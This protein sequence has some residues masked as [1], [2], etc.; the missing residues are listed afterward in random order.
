ML[1]GISWTDFLTVLA[2]LLLVYYS[3]LFLAL[4][5]RRL[6]GSTKL[7]HQPNN[8]LL[9]G[10]GLVDGYEGQQQLDAQ[11][12]LHEFKEQLTVYLQP[13]AG[14]SLHGENLMGVLSGLLIQY[15]QAITQIGLPTLKELIAEQLD[16][17]GVQFSGSLDWEEL[18]EQTD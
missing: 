10:E 5:R 18:I 6:F 3:T 9:H 12:T 2:A 11:L 14:K 15:P 1:K 8:N 16:A 17:L 7:P 13:Y 4:Y